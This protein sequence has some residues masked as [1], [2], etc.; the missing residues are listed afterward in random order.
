MAGSEQE[1]VDGAD[2][3]LFAGAVWVLTPDRRPPTTPPTRRCAAWSPTLGADVVALAPEHHDALVAVVSH[4]PHLTAASLMRLADD[5]ATEH[6]ALLRLAAGG[7]RDMT[8]IASGHPGHLAR[9]LRGE[10]RRD[11]RRARRPRRVAAGGPRRSWPTATAPRSWPCSSRPG[12]RGPTCP[13]R[14]GPSVDLCE[15]RVPVPDRPGVLAEVTTLAGALDV[16]IADLEIAHSSEGDRGVLILW[17]RRPRPSACGPASSSTGYRPAVLPLGV[18]PWPC[19]DPLPVDAARRPARRGRAGA[20]VEEHH[21]PG[22]GVRG[23]G[24]GRQRARRRARGRRHR[25]PWSRASGPS[26]SRSRPTGRRPRCVVRGCAGRPPA[27]AGPRRRPPVGHHRAASCCRS[28][29]SAPAPP[30]ST[31]P[32]ACGPGRW[33]TSS[34]RSARSAAPCRGGRRA[35]APARRGR[36]RPAG[37]RR[38]GAAR[39]RVEPVPL[40]PAAGRARPCAPGCSVAADH[41]A[42]VPALRRHDH[43]GDGGVRRRRS[44]QPDDRTWVVE[45]SALPGHDLR[46]RARRQRG[47]VPFAAA[48]IVGGRV[49][50][51]GLGT[52]LAAGRPRRSSTCSSAWAPTVERRTD[53]TT[54]TGTGHAARD[55]GRPV[56]ALRHR[57]DPRRRRRLRR[58][59]DAG[60]GHRLHPRQGDRPH[61]QRRRRAAPGRHRRRGGARR[62]RRPPGPPCGPPRSRPTTTTAWRWPSPCSACGRPGIRIAD[63]ACVAKTFPGFWAMLERLRAAAGA[64]RRVPAS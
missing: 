15:V 56:A 31:A 52:R 35:R 46:R 30:G 1:G 58:R 34:R 38:G 26:A 20:R 18:T 61:R 40:R 25:S 37:R 17:S 53:R 54:V 7:F 22:A 2:P 48:A 57:P 42:R 21:Q 10:P 14:L 59:P 24:R 39:R 28:P 64:G 60:H 16:N 36:R 44:T 23:A 49:T 8:R 33:A 43:R 62:L 19:T 4:V 45:P 27:D 11:P 9:H 12:R 13:P 50:V 63:P 41:R 5:R 6:R 32:S 51:E 29:R 55:R 3:D 47:V